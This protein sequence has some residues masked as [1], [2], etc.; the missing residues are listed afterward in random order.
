M[1]KRIGWLDA[2]GRPRDRSDA[3]ALATPRRPWLIVSRDR[4]ELPDVRENLFR[5]TERHGQLKLLLKRIS[6][7]T[8]SVEFGAGNPPCKPGPQSCGYNWIVAAIKDLTRI[9]P[10][11]VESFQVGDLRQGG[12]ISV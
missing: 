4:Q 2:H 7:R 8:D 6:N 3:A 5:K 11:P 1:L 10:E 12:D 9:F